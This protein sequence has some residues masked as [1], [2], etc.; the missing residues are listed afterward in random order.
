[1]AAVPVQVLPRRIAQVAQPVR[2]VAL[3]GTSMSVLLTSSDVL[4][5]EGGR[6]FKINFPTASFPPALTAYRP[7]AA[8]K[9]AA[10]AKVVCCENAFAALSSNGEMFTFSFP[11]VGSS[12]VIEANATQSKEGKGGISAVSNAATVKPQRVWALRKQFSAVKDVAL[13]SDGAIVLCTESGHV[14]FRNRLAKTAKFQRMPFLQRVVRVAASNAGAFAALRANCVSEP[15]EVAGN[16]LSK[17][18]EAVQPYLGWA[19]EGLQWGCEEHRSANRLQ[20]QTEMSAESPTVIEEGTDVDGEGQGESEDVAIKNDIRIAKHLL[21]LLD[22]DENSRREVHRGIFDGVELKYGADLLVQ[23]S[24]GFAFPLH[25]IVLAARSLVLKDVLLGQSV[26]DNAVSIELRHSTLVSIPPK[27]GSIPKLVFSGVHPLTVLL[28]AT[29]LYTDDVPA[30]WDRRVGMAVCSQLGT[31]GPKTK[32]NPAQIRAELHVLAK[33]LR[34]PVLEKV[35]DSPV[36]HVLVPTLARDM[37]TLF[38]TAQPG[39][40]VTCSSGDGCEIE[41][42]LTS[43]TNP[44]ASD[45]VLELAD[46]RVYCHAIMLR[47]R[48]PFFAGFFDD[49][50]WTQKRWRPDGT[51]HVDLRHLRWQVMEFVFRYLYS[52]GGEEIFEILDFTDNVD[53]VLDFIFE[54]MHVASELLLDRLLLI[55]SSVVL[56]LVNIN[57]VCAVLSDATHFHAT[58]LV[59]SLQDYM[60]RNMETLLESHML[61]DLSSPL[62]KQ[63]SAFVRACQAKKLPVTRSGV[64]V[65]KALENCKDWLA[66][67]D[68]P[69]PFISGRRSG[70]GTQIRHSPRLSPVAVG[71]SSGSKRTRCSSMSTNPVLSTPVSPSPSPQISG[72]ATASG[73]EFFL[74]DDDMRG[75][76][77]PLDLRAA[78]RNLHTLRSGHSAPSSQIPAIGTYSHWK[79]RV[80]Q[81]P[82]SEMD[83]RGIMAETESQRATP[84]QSE[85]LPSRSR[86]V[87]FDMHATTIASTSHTLQKAPLLS[88]TMRFKTSTP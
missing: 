6:S 8:Q 59:A 68:I 40:D 75:D 78:P 52:G 81:L 14:Y 10:I 37:Q 74:M 84:P 45:T 49:A 55:C 62:V 2:N 41:T 20:E 54:V 50:D 46:R 19:A 79:A 23:V 18:L 11:A 82:P 3:S 70:A 57:N 39:G 26:K 77:P 33:L 71:N 29:Y 25:R 7:P 30:L 88:D 27:S 53:N 1:M 22:C 73:D 80:A 15:V 83:L 58:Q 32:V 9:N 64:L 86:V 76:I 16:T 67:Q 17:D 65:S 85:M 63:L 4:C 61:D 56:K 13:G 12:S 87:G 24:S 38:E 28:L 5:F 35:L 34:L 48:S 21:E 72:D 66:L 69:Q 36:K 31:L 44:L 47:A 43:S 51:L 42:L 60:A